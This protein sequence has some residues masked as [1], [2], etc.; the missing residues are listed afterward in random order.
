MKTADIKE[1]VER[2]PFRPFT[3]RLS[4]G[5]Q[6]TFKQPRDIGASKDCSMVFYFAEPRGAVRI[7]AENI[8]EV[9]EN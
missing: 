5:V 7:D 8:V 9:I 4:N 3:L 2:E 1:V 6:Y